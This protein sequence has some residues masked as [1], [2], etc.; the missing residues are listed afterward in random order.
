MTD[1]R[2]VAQQALRALS[3]KVRKG[4]PVDF[5][6]ALAVIAYQEELRRQREANSWKARF[7]QWFR[8][9]GEA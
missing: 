7:K 2:T 8:V 5:V 1:L 3:D 6:D 9:R 4:E